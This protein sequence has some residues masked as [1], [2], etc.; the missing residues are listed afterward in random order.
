[1]NKL[2]A[3]TGGKT[4]PRAGIQRAVTRF[5]ECV[6]HLRA[7]PNKHFKARWAS[8]VPWEVM[9]PVKSGS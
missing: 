1:M 2:T 5:G 6:A 4:A 3:D 8:G 9:R 7:P